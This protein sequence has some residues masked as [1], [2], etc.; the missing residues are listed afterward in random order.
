VRRVM[1]AVMKDCES[2]SLWGT[3][4]MWGP[5][6]LAGIRFRD[7]EGTPATASGLHISSMHP[8]SILTAPQVKIN[9][10]WKL[11]CL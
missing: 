10:G 8:G 4:A 9:G 5:R 7:A 11:G 3:V 1:P 6:S 2:E